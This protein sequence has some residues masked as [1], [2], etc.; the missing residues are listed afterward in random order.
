MVLLSRKQISQILILQ[1][2]LVGQISAAVL[3]TRDRL[4]THVMKDYNSKGLPVLNHTSTTNIGISCFIVC[5]NRFDEISGELALVMYFQLSW[6]EERITW[7]ASEFEGIQSILVPP[8]AIWRPE[9]FI[10]Q[11]TDRIQKIGN[12]SLFLRLHSNGEVYWTPADEFKLSCSVDVTYFPFDK[13]TCIIE[14]T[15]IV[16]DNSELLMYSTNHILDMTYFTNNSQ[17]DVLPSN[18]SNCTVDRG[19]SCIEVN[20]H[21][22]RKSEFYIVYIFVP[23]LFLGLINNLV[24]V[25][26]ASCGER[27]SVAVT[28]FLS[29][30]VYM[31]IVNDIVPQSSAPLSYLY[32]YLMFLMVYSSAIMFL[33]I[34]SLR[35]YNIQGNVPCLIKGVVI[36]M[37]CRC[38]RYILW[39][40]V[41]NAG[42][43]I[44]ALVMQ[45][46]QKENAAKRDENDF[47]EN[48]DELEG[49]QEAEH[50]VNK[51]SE[52]KDHRKSDE[53]TWFHVGRTFDIVWFL[54]LYVAY[55]G[56]SGYTVTILYLNILL[57]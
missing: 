49:Q 14:F 39:K 45:R 54:L 47:A 55:L 38:L 56:G 31:S 43:I 17:W 7:N 11:S 27:N 48:T 32:L 40:R 5:I 24:F 28:T 13:Q 29:F 53:I 16:Y 41:K 21:L 50:R 26:P 30:V 9:F 1:I 42:N 36:L 57:D 44:P 6:I 35:I 23:L 3:T 4:Y 25:M 22:K 51:E 52:L 46:F 15:G 2:L 8:D 12:L 20:L 34:I 33:C 18:V 37:R 10:I 19:T